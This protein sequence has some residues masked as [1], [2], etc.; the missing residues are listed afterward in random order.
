M[1]FTGLNCFKIVSIEGIYFYYLG[2][3]KLVSY[4]RIYLFVKVSEHLKTSTSTVL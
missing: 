3:S 2:N 1:V 4:R